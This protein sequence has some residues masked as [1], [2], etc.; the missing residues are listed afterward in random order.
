MRAL[1]SSTRGA[2]HFNPLVPFARAFERAGHELLF[3][4]PPDLA[5][6]VDGAGFEFWRFDPPPEDELGA[7]W[8]R[9]PELPPVEAN[10]VVVGELFGRLNTTAALPRLREACEEWRPDVVV[11][12]PNEY[13]SAFAAELH[14]IPHARVAIGLASTE[15]LGTGIAAS[16]IEVIR[17]A[18]GLP[19]DPDA[20]RLRRAPYLSLFPP[21]LDEG[22]QPD[23]QRFH[24]PAWDEPP[25]ELLDW[26]PGRE[27]E[28]LVYVTFGSVAGSFPQALPVYGVAM[29]AVAELP[30]RVLLTVGR[31]LDLD[32]L[33]PAPEN[34]RV[35]RWVPQQDVLGHAA[36]ALVHGGSGSTLGALA[37]G[38]PLVVMPLFADQPQNARRVAEVGAGVAVE[39]NRDDLDAT[40]S[41]LRQAIRTVLDDPS[42]G[43][44]AR[45]LADE[46]RAQPPVDDALPLFE[47]FARS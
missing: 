29:R 42:Y 10:E 39:P 22:A 21:T 38:M 32:A 2:G 11:R 9:V 19:P 17:Q 36:A 40:V 30:V 6:A 37:A 23:T 3:A 31:E 18:E 14:G 28:P 45:A 46:L 26:W 5:G 33:P 8:G 43:R 44:A 1:F 34:V 4:G 13:G 20:D 15:E 35:E 27:R 7:V 41:P 16:A 25:G 12:D 47:R 24:D